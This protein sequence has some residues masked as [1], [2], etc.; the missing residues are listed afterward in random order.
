MAI[1]PRVVA[2]VHT[3]D[4][5]GD[6]TAEVCRVY[7]VAPGETVEA[8]VARTLRQTRYKPERREQVDHYEP[9]DRVEL[10]VVVERQADAE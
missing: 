7:D 2:L 10:K 4:Y 3:T 1:V 9:D 8:L 5:R 6:H